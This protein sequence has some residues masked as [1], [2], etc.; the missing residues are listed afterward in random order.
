MGRSRRIRRTPRAA[1][2]FPLTTQ[3][4]ARSVGPLL[5]EAGRTHAGIARQLNHLNRANEP[6]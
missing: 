6:A 3:M 4:K 5:K 2:L 1:Q